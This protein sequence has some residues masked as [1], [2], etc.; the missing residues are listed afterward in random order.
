MI[1]Y[2]LSSFFLCIAADFPDHEN[3]FGLIVVLKS[4]EQI[5]IRSPHDWVTTQSNASGLP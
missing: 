1:L 4:F 2:V 5:D 3:H